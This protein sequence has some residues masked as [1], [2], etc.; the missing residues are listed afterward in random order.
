MNYSEITQWLDNEKWVLMTQPPST[1]VL[2][3]EGNNTLCEAVLTQNRHVINVCLSKL[4]SSNLKLTFFFPFRFKGKKP[5]AK[6]EMMDILTLKRSC[7][8]LRSR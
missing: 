3:T 8:G 5:A 7:S 6:F 2:N 1:E 4:L